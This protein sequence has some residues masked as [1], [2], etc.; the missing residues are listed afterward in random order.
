MRGKYDNGNIYDDGCC[1][2]TV[3]F[4]YGGTSRVLKSSKIDEDEEYNVNHLSQVEPN[5]FVI[6]SRLPK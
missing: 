4:C 1:H 3:A 6:K 2:N 5:V